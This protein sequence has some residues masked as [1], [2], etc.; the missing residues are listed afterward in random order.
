M[1]LLFICII[2]EQFQHSLFA[3]VSKFQLEFGIWKEFWHRRA[4][5]VSCLLTQETRD[6]IIHCLQWTATADSDH[7][8]LHEHCLHW[9]NAKVFAIRCVQQACSSRQQGSLV[10]VTEWSKESYVIVNVKVFRQFPQFQV[11]LPILY[12]SFIVASSHYEMNFTGQ[13]TG[14]RLELTWI[15][16]SGMSSYQTHRQTIHDRPELVWQWRLIDVH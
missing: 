14:P 9:H 10:V 4:E 11:M 1:E 7:R 15:I 3:R 2:R 8:A 6:L 12:D 16:N 13:T 5:R